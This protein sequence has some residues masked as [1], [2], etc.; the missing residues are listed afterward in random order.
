MPVKG[1]NKVSDD[2]R[3]D[4]YWFLEQR[5]K[6]I[7]ELLKLHDNQ[8]ERLKKELAEIEKKLE[9]MSKKKGK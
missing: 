9:E 4:D 5:K 8:Y 2:Q 6:A 1:Y 7:N 3:I